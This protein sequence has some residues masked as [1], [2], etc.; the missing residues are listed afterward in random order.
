MWG[1]WH[2]SGCDH[3]ECDLTYTFGVKREP[4]KKFALTHFF[5]V[6]LFILVYAAWWQAKQTYFI[7]KLQQ[8]IF[9]LLLGSCTLLTRLESHDLTQV[10]N[11]RTWD[12]W[13]ERTWLFMTSCDFFSTNLC[14]FYVMLGECLF[15]KPGNLQLR[16]CRRQPKIT[17]FGFKEHIHL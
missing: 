7:C 3:N 8:V 1:G 10:A 11:L 12:R 16:Q 6:C 9:F 5:F 17:K 13:L 4:Q 15:H 2:T 14:I